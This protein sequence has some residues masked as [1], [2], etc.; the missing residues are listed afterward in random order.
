MTD[1]PEASA[2]ELLRPIFKPPPDPNDDPDRTDDEDTD[3]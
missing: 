1:Q 3:Q 2:W